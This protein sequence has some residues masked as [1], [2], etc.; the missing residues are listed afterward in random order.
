VLLFG[1]HRR[2]ICLLLV[3]TPA[4]AISGCVQR[5]LKIESEPPGATVILDGKPAG[6]TPLEVS[7]TWYGDREIILEKAGHESV[8]VI[9]PVPT[10]WWQIFPLDFIT[11]VLLPIPITD[12]HEFHYVLKP[13]DSSVETY[14]NT[15]KRADDF[16]KKAAGDE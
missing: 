16:R 1:K 2:I 12:K 5:L 3:L 10:P 11:D 8:R 4:M 15:R 9:E 14:K 13:H 6:A 7:F